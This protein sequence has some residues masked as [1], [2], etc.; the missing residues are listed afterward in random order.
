[1]AQYKY[2]YYFSAAQ[3]VGVAVSDN[4]TGPFVDS[5]KPLIDKTLEGVPRG[6]II[7]P[8][9]FIGPQNRE[10]LHLLGQWQYGRS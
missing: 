7:D 10:M 3:N 5:G 1:M 6:Q 8:D 2:F 4:P 9:V